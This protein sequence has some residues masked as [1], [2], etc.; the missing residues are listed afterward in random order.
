MAL[1]SNLLSGD[2]RLEACA[3][4]DP[5]HIVLGSVG[6]HVAKIQ[7]ALA[8]LDGASIDSKEAL[9]QTYG[10][11]TAAAVLAYKKKRNIINWSY[12]Q[13]ADNIVGKMT[14]GALDAEMCVKEKNYG[15]LRWVR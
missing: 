2:R 8:I 4:S 13:Q 14:I 6:K 15:R 1:K 9:S 11:S 3:A 5:A 12:Q 10:R 7:I